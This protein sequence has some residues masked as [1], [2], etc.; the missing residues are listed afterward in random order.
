M[1]RA[2]WLGFKHF[3]MKVVTIN[4]WICSNGCVSGWDKRCLTFFVHCFI[5]VRFVIG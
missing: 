5:P 3:L 4:C 1:Q 2:V